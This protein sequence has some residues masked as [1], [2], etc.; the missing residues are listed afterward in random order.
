MLP[1]LREHFGNPSSGHAF[2]R[3][4]LQGVERA[5][6]QIAAL[7]NC[8]SDE[9]FFTCGGTEANNWAIRGTA[10][11][12]EQ[13]ATIVTSAIEHPATAGACAWLERRGWRI[14]R[15]PVNDH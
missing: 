13:P 9:I 12:A 11:A 8:N 6:E 2:G 4:A 14:V 3:R 1:Y 15:L 7:L 10:E 5:R